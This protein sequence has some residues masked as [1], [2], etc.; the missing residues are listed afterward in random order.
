MIAYS[1]GQYPEASTVSIS[2]LKRRRVLHRYIPNDQEMAESR[3]HRSDQST[4]R[5]ESRYGQ[6][7]LNEKP[8]TVLLH[9]SIQHL[10]PSVYHGHL[11]TSKKEGSEK[12]QIGGLTFSMLEGQDEMAIDRATYLRERND[13]NDSITTGAPLYSRST[14][15]IQGGDEYFESSKSQM[16]GGGGGGGEE[17]GESPYELQRIRDPAEYAAS[18]EQLLANTSAAGYNPSSAGNNH[19]YSRERQF[20]TSTTNSV[21]S[22]LMYQSQ[23]PGYNHRQQQQSQQQQQ[24][25]QFQPQPQRQRM[26]EFDFGFPPSANHHQDS[27]LSDRQRSNSAS[28]SQNRSPQQQ[29]QQSQNSPYRGG[30]SSP[31]YRSRDE[32]RQYDTSGRQLS[33]D[34]YPAG[35]GGGRR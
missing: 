19:Y 31:S 25:P 23:Q 32:E 17:D 28:P 22:P 5:L 10:L 29:Q 12:T 20:S 21:N 34:Q 26:E 8:F 1:D 4:H 35:M 9:K 11:H 30:N 16:L 24:Q 27:I 2:W 13:D 6:P 15:M 18:T 14:T 3:I 33:Y 7:C